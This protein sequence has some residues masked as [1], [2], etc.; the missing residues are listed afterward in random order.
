MTT[1]ET[2]MYCQDYGDR[3]G[4]LKVPDH[5][6]TMLFDDIGERPILWCSFCG[7]TAHAQYA[8]I[9]EALATKGPEFLESFEREIDK[10][11]TELVRS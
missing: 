7:P 9:T 2:S 11:H 10:A 6:Y 3:V 4:C 5:R 1:E 8:A